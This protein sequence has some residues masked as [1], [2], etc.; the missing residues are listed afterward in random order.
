MITEFNRTLT[1]QETDLLT[2]TREE[3]M[4][5]NQNGEF[6]DKSLA[7]LWQNR[8]KK[9]S[10]AYKE[11]QALSIDYDESI[12]SANEADATLHLEAD[13]YVPE[14]LPTWPIFRDNFILDWMT[15]RIVVTEEEADAMFIN[16]VEAATASDGEQNGGETLVSTSE[17]AVSSTIPASEP[18]TTA[19]EATPASQPKRRGR[20][21]GTKNKAKQV[22]KA[23][24]KVKAK[25]KTVRKTKATASRG[26][27]PTS[28]S[29][30]A[31]RL[32]EMYQG[33]GWAR[34]DII[35][36]LQKQLELGAAYAAT[37]YQKYA[38]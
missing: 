1:Q 2:R 10:E 30:K 25:S 4:R 27:K 24:R 3:M 18:S 38:A 35:E 7:S 31:Q 12:V 11:L 28:A 26:R 37:L 13:A 9:A 14:Q 36:K 15:N 5:K 33:K 20:P 23:V 32:I 6:A 16:D 8:V 22:T 17:P 29:A 34:K 21:P 19:T